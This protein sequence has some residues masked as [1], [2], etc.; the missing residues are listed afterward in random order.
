MQS[1]N[2]GA[3]QA[4][5]DPLVVPGLIAG[6]TAKGRSIFNAADKAAIVQLY[7]SGKATKNAAQ[8][9]TKNWLKGAPAPL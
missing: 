6:K 3:V 8:H 2:V 1:Q 5:I 7:K 4:A 9:V